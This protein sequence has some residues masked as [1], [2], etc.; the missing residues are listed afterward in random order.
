MKILH[1]VPTY[2]PAV[3]YGGPIYSVHALCRSL[4][5]AGHRVHV[6]TTSVDG[7][8]DSNVPHGRPV[9]LDGVQVCYFRSRWLRRLYYSADLKNHLD[10]IAGD[11]DI[12]HLHSVFLYPTWM[13][14]RT[15]MRASV[16]YVLSPR[17]MLVHDLITRR[18]TLIKR[19]WIR[20]V[21]RGNLERAARIHLTS[22]E[23]RR[24]LTDLGL[25]LAP[26]T[27]IP[28]GVD[29]PCAFSPDAVSAD[30]RELVAKG[31][32][33]LSFGRISWK[34]GLDQLVKAIAEIPDARAVIAGHDEE[35]FEPSLRKAAQECGVG[36]RLRILPRQINGPDKEALFD[37]A[38][39]FALPSLSENFGNV[40]AEAMIRAR[41]VV[42]TEAVGASEFVK[43]SGGGLVVGIGHRQLV[44]ALSE[45]LKSEELLAAMGAAGAKYARECL[46]WN[47]ISDRFEE[48]YREISGLSADTRQRGQIA[49]I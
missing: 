15:A 44:A 24:A 26:T 7:R 48:M 14:A 20:L 4:A 38:R 45:L 8:R 29:A 37:A 13:G 40:V 36:E 47:N 41:P 23:E 27:M 19:T 43:A 5:A 22:E 28:N 35:G 6:F 12:V 2:F 32:D 39:L 30:V 17:G 16:P 31:F 11:F 49:S 46:T 10:S 34:K 3:R 18:S 33:I 9:N 25:A 42:V 21:E 1:V